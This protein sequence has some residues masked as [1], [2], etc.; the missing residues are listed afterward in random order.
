M[1]Y[2]VRSMDYILSDLI[3]PLSILLAIDPS[4]QRIKFR[5]TK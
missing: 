3:N 4:L 5:E 2:E 1:I